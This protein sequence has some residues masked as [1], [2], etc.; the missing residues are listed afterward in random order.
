M[1]TVFAVVAI[2]ARRL[3]EPRLWSGPRPVR[4]RGQD[5][6]P[7]RRDMDVSSGGAGTQAKR[8]KLGAER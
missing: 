4:G 3:L 5:V 8:A 2:I 1:L 7:D 6:A